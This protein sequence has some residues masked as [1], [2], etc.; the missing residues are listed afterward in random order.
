MNRYI[1]FLDILGFADLVMTK[2]LEEVKHRMRL[3]M[4][5]IQIAKSG[6]IHPPAPEVN[7]KPPHI[8]SF[9]DTYVLISQDL[10]EQAIRSFIL[11]S[12]LLTQYLYAQSLGVRGAITF[13]EADFIPGTQHLV[14]KGI[15]AAAKLEKKQDWLGVIVD[16]PSMPEGAV[17]LFEQP[18]VA[19]LFTRWNVPLKEGQTLQDALVVNWRYNLYV[20]G[21]TKSLFGSPPGD[22]EKLKIQNTL[23]F[24]KHMVNTN[25][26]IGK[27]T[28]PD[29][30]NIP[31][32]I[33]CNVR[34]AAWAH[35]S[36]RM[37][38]DDY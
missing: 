36:E 23:V 22:P 4:F 8:F 19:P 30:K 33:G 2:S 10:S 31:W 27:V 32:L 20:E 1:A 28:D 24:A 11:T 34:S 6:G 13:G 14:G 29:G 18:L 37:H 9:S 16:L 15:V 21:G 5:S 25:R 38:G 3:A 12:A 35:A 17:Q 26:H 7:V